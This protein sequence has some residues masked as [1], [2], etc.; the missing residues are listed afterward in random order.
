[1]SEVTSEAEFRRAVGGPQVAVVDFFASW[2]GPCQNIAPQFAKLASAYP[3]LRFVKVNVDT[4]GDVAGKY[5]VSSIPQFLVFKAG[6]EIDRVQ[7]AGANELAA[8]V[9]RH[10]SSALMEGGHVLGGAVGAAHRPG[11]EVGVA[12]RSAAA[13]AAER[14]MKAAQQQKPQ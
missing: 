9:Q 8:M 4:L 5:G 2:C 3:Q 7:G 13:A 14:R 12:G 11:E 10:A 6:T 1:M